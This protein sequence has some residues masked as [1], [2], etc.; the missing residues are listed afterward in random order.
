MYVQSDFQLAN[1]I[2]RVLPM[3]DQSQLTFL[4]GRGLFDSVLIVN[5]TVDFLKRENLR[6]AIIK[7]DF[8]KVNDSVSWDFLVYMRRRLGFNSK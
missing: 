7:L 4:S 5:E 2:K 6:G 1:R 3:I 8:E